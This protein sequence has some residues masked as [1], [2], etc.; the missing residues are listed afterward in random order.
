MVRRFSGHRQALRRVQLEVLLR[1][2]VRRMRPAEANGQEKRLV[3]ANCFFHELDRL[4][5]HHAVVGVF[6]GRVEHDALE[7]AIGVAPREW[8]PC[9]DLIGRRA[10][11]LVGFAGVAVPGNGILELVARVIDL[12]HLDGR[13]SLLPEVLR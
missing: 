4:A 12:A 2:D 13:V 11:G 1:S 5:R 8:S 9:G 6:V 3:P 10:L 7:F